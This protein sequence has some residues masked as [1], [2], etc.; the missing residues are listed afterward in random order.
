M[1]YSLLVG[2]LEPDM[3][4]DV[5]AGTVAADLTGAIDVSMHWKKPD[6]TEVDVALTAVS[7][8]SG[9]LKRVWAAGDTD[10][11]GTHYGRVAVTMASG[12]VQSF[13]NDGSWIIWHVY[14]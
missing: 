10:I 4:I 8:A 2:D 3:R 5:L 14:E 1:S 11:P 6:G 7:L 12:E 13:P 9:Q